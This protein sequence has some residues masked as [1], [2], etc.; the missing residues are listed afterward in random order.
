MDELKKQQGT[1]PMLCQALSIISNPSVNSNWSNR[2]EMLNSNENRRFSVQC[3]LEIWQM[4]LEK[5]IGHLFYATSSFVYHF[6][7]QSAVRVWKRPIWV[8]IGNLWPRVTLELDRWHWKTI[9]HL[10]YTTSRFVHHFTTIS[11]FKLK[12]QSGNIQFGSKS[13]IFFHVTLKFDGWSKKTIGRLL[14]ALC[15]IS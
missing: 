13:G 4:I 5:T 15:I 9:W 6:G 2:P 10:F 12:L 14:Q 1:Y 7:H 3:D 8:K 11:E